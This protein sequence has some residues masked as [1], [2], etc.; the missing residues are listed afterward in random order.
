[1]KETCGVEYRAFNR[2]LLKCKRAKNHAGAA[3][4]KYHN[5]FSDTCPLCDR[6]GCDGNRADCKAKEAKS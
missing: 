3:E 5:G 6:E 2:V 4:D 1:M